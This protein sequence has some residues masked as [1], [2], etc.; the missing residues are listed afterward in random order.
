MNII[1]NVLSPIVVF[2]I[3][4]DNHSY[5]YKIAQAL[6]LDKCMHAHLHAH[7]VLHSIRII[8]TSYAKY[9]LFVHVIEFVCAIP[10]KVVP[11]ISK[12]SYVARIY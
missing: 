8:F 10:A 6:N 4:S 1:F 7:F 11:T 12:R 2:D 5:A 9:L 3:Q